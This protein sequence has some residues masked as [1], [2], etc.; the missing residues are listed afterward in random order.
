MDRLRA[1][2]TA[3]LASNLRADRAAR[4]F[5]AWRAAL[6][7][8]A[9][10]VLFVAGFATA[11]FAPQWTPT[12]QDASESRDDWR[13][14]VA[15]YMK[16]YTADTLSEV[17]TDPAL[18]VASL[19]PLGE[20]LGTSL[21]P[22][23]IDIAGLPFKRA[24]LLSYDKAPLAQLAYLDPQAGPVLFCIIADSRPDAPVSNA[25]VDGFATSS[26]AKDGR[27]FMVIGRM[28]AER[29]AAI[30]GQLVQRF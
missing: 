13:H 18:Q 8:G 20:R 28:P 30:A 2:L 3:G 4:T 19:K 6:V 12:Q 21:S 7:A 29:A 10:V 22:E 11:R 23:R 25:N 1:S 27:G 15:A 26:W 16:L 17:P 14:A 24:E 9:A 5:G